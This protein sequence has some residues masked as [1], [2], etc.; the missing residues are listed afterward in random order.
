MNGWAAH[1]DDLAASYDEHTRVGWHPND[2][3]GELLAGLGLTPGSVLDLGAG[4]GQTARMLV[5]LYPRARLTLVEPSSG[6]ADLA[7]AKIPDAAVVVADAAEHLARVEDRHDLVTAV[8]CLELVPDLFEVLRL[9]TSRLTPGGHL[10]VT[11][12][13]LI[14]GSTGQ[15][16]PR[17]V[18]ARGARVVT[19]HSREAV[20]AGAAALGLERVASRDFTAYRRGDTHDAVIYEAVIW[21]SAVQRL[22]V[23]AEPAPM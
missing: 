6:M 1:F 19:R 17:Q 23:T 4:T 5:G 2:R 12:E 21:R 22:G 8:G 20:A 14:A 16:V 15:S 7:R 3:L 11:H 18:M 13:P 9:A 10:A